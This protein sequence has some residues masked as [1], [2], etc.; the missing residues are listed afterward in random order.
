[1]KKN[2]LLLISLIFVA[3]VLIGSITYD[4]IRGSLRAPAE[5]LSAYDP[6]R[7]QTP[8]ASVKTDIRY[9]GLPAHEAKYWKTVHE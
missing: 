7:T 6:V 3:L 4:N 5:T 2:D 1:M 9:N 8:A